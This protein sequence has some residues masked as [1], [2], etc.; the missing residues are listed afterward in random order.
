[1]AGDEQEQ[2]VDGSSPHADRV[3][4][5][6]AHLQELLRRQ[7]LG[8]APEPA[9]A[10][11][12]PRVPRDGPLPLS[13]AQQRLWYL[14]EIES[15]SIEYNT[16]RV[17]RL[18][19]DLDVEALASALHGLVL[20]HEPLR[21]S[22][23]SVDGV[24]VQV[25]HPGADVPVR[26]ADLSELP[27][28]DRRAALDRCVLE[29]ATCPFDLRN[30]PV[31]RVRLLRLGPRDHVLAVSMH[32]IVTDGWSLGVLVDDLAVLY[33]AGLG[34]GHDDLPPLLAHFADLAAWQRGR[35]SSPAL[36]DRL[37]YWCRALDGLEP[38][39]LPTDL[40]RPPVRTAVG[41]LH[42]FQIPAPVTAQLR[43]L[44]RDAGATLFMTLVT[45][46]QV[47]LARWSG[48]ADVAV[49]TAV[50][51]RDRVEAERLIGFFVNTLVLRTRVDES[52]SA[53]DL[54]RVVRSTVL[55]A[56]A[57]AEVPFQQVVEALRPDRDPS[58]PALAEVAVNLRTVPG[59]AVPW[60]GLRVAE[61][62]PPVV[63]ASMDLSFDFVD[64]DGVLEAH[65]GYSTDLFT[66]A[67][68]R[69]M[70]VHLVT[71]LRG[72]AERPGGCVA[73]LPMLGRGERRRLTGL[74]PGSGATPGTR[75]A[76]QLFAAQVAGNPS[77][78]AVISDDVQLSYAEL[79]ERANRMAR[80]LLSRGAG[81]EE[82]VAVALPPSIDMIVAVLAV[83]KSG[84]A[85]LPLDPDH[86]AERLRL[87][88]AD[89]RPLLLVTTAALEQRFPAS[90]PKIVVDAPEVRASARRLPGSELAGHE[91]TAPLLAAHPAY[92]TYTSG[93]TGHPKGVVV[94]HAGV[95]D[96][97]TGQ[98]EQFRAGR[99]ARVLQF[100]SLCFDAAFSEL[101]MSLLSGGTLVVAT[102]EQMLPGDPLAALMARHR[103][104]HVTLPPSALT[105]LPEAGIAGDVTLIV[106][107]EACPPALARKWSARRRMINAYGP[108]EA[109]VCASMSAPLVPAS[110]PAATVPIGRPFGGVRVHVLDGW[111]R[112]VPAGVPG[113]I[114][115]SG[116]ALARGYLHRR[117]LTAQRFV[118]AP[119]G[120]PGG[121]MYRTGDRARW[122]GDGTLDFL[123][124]VDD[125]VKLRGFRIELGE[126][127]AVLSRHHGVSGVAAAVRQDERGTRRLV[128]YVTSSA[129]ALD[130]AQLRAF[131]RQRLPEH[132]VPSVI[133]PLDQLPLNA[134][135]K[136]D[137]RALPDPGPRRDPTRERVA[138]RNPAEETLVRI[139]AE[140]L[141]V[142][143]IGV[144]DNFFDLG[145]DS[146][147]SLQVVARAREAGLQLTAKQTF[148][149]PTIA[150][151]AV[152]AI[153]ASGD[154]QP[155]PAEQHARSG[156]V[157]LTP[158]QH[159]FFDHL[160][161]SL[162]QFSQSIFL[163][164]T[165]DLHEGA[166]VAAITALLEQHDALRMRATRSS[167]GWRLTIAPAEHGEVVQ[168]ADLSDRD[169][170]EQDAVM[171]AATA[172]A[173]VGFPL[174]TGPM[175][176]ARLFLL[177][178]QRRPRLF[179]AA[180]HL[181][182]DG[183]SWPILL[184]DL[185]TGYRQA[186]RGERI[187]LRPRTSSFRGWAIRLTEFVAAGGLAGDAD[188]WAGAEAAAPA[189]ARLPLD[190]Q[191][192]NTV[193][194]MRT[195]TATLDAASTAALFREVP[196][197]Y[198]TR[199]DDV[200]LS[201]LGRVLSAWTGHGPVLIAVEG[202][203]RE[204]LFD[205]ADLSRTVGWFT[206]LFPLALTIPPD[207]DWGE[208]LKS[209]KEQVRAVPRNGLS[210]GALRYLGDRDA[211]LGHGPEPEVSFNYLGQLFAAEAESRLAHR[212]L[213]D[214]G[215]ERS[216]R[217]ERQ[218]L[219][220][221]NS[222]VRDGELEFRWS[223][224][225]TLHHQET[226]E[227]LAWALTTAVKEII[228]HCARPG[229]GGRTPSD[230]PLAS[231]DRAAVD[232]IA[233]DGRSVAD[234]YPLTP[235][236]SGILFHALSEA[237]RDIYTGHFGAR[238]DGITDPEALA[239]AWQR[240]VDRTPAL[241]TA[242]IWQDVA[243]P[244]QVVYSEARVP[245]THYD[246][247]AM[248][249]DEQQDALDLVWEERAGFRFDLTAA[250]LL[251]L[252]IVR[253]TDTA[254]QLFWTTHHMV[255]DGWSFADVLA[256]VFQQYAILTGR[257]Q[258][259]P[260]ARRPF[261]DY[262]AWL[263]G[264]D[265]AEAERYWRAVMD[266]FTVPTPLP[267][268]RP[269]VRA[270]ETRSSRELRLSM[271][272]ER[273]RR[274]YEYAR[275]AR[276]TVN[277]VVQGAWAILLSRYTG[278][279][280][281]C[282]GATVSG[283]PPALAGAESV[284][285]LFINTVPV[286]IDVDGQSGVTDWLRGI[287]E[288][289]LDS[290]SH[291]Y[292][293]LSQ[294]QQVSGVGG[295]P[296]GS[297]LFNSILVF[298]NYPHHSAA[299]ARYGLRVGD[300]LGDEHTNYA[301]TCT[302]YAA[303]EL[304]LAVGYDP[305][306]FDSSTIE[307]MAG[308]LVT[309]LGAVATAPDTAVA[310]LPMLT[311]AETRQLLVERN[312]TAV[313][314][315]P[316]RCV[317]E[318][319]AEQVRSTPEAMAVSSAG[320][321]L[322]FAG[323]EERANQLAHYLTGQGAGP[324]VL[325]GVCLGRGS[326][327]VIALLAVLK[328]GSAFVPLDPEYPAQRLKIMLADAAVPVVITEQPLLD[329]VAGHD[330]AIVCL[331]RDRPLL[332]GLPSEPPQTGVTPEDLAYVVYTSGTTG[333]PKGVMVEHRQVHHMVRA[334]DAR[335]GLA[336]L[337]PR[338]MSVSSLSVDLF[339]GDFLLATLF[340]GSLVVCPQES[341]ADPVALVDLLVQTR[342]ALM[343]TVPTLA[344]AVAAEFAWRGERP[345]SLRL[346]MV[347]S[348]G[349]PADAAAEV[350]AALGPRTVVVN[351]YG[352]TETTV[353]SSVFA[354]EAE[355]VGEAA[356]VPI[357]RPLANTRIYLLDAQLRPV[358]TG[359]AGEC[360]I[361]GDGISRG[362]W[363]GPAI[364]AER[365]LPDPFAAQPG[366]RMYRTGDLVRWRAD[367]NLEYLGRADDQVKVGG[368]RVELG[369]VEAALARHPQVA[370]ASAAISQK[371][372]GRPARLVGY[373]VPVTGAEPDPAEL[374]LF[375]A[376]RLP[377][378]AVPSVLM[379]L[380][381]LPFNPGGTI[382]RRA[383]PA[384]AD[385]VS[386]RT[387]YLAPRSG[388]ERVLAQIWAEVLD[389]ERV[390]VH[391]NFFD[392]GGNSILSIRV[393]S[394]IRTELHLAASPRQLF[395]TPT[396]AGTAAT[397]DANAVADAG[398]EPAAWSATDR[399]G[400]PPLSLAQQRL[401]FLNEFEPE[402]AEYN[403][404]TVLR[405]HGEL[406]VDA[407]RAAL[408]QVVARHEPLRTTYADVAGRAAQVIHRAPM[409]VLSLLDL[410]A[411]AAGE[412]EVSMLR[413]ARAEAARPFDL[414][415]GPVFR[416]TLI[417]LGP[418][419]HVMVLVVH[420]IAAD[421]WSMG[422]LTDELGA[423]YSAAR[424]GARA[425]LPPLPVRYADY[426]GWQR[427]LLSE[428]AMKEHAKYWLGKLEGLRPLELPTDR[429]RPAVRTAEGQL[430]LVEIDSSVAAALKDLARQ[431]D[432]TLFMAL[433]AAVQVLLAR[434]SGQHDIAVGV[435]T[436]GR[437]RRE[438]E[439]LIGLF[440]NTVV[441]RCTVE[442]E[443]SFPEFLARVRATMLEAFVHAEMPFDGLVEIMRPR[444]DPSR[445]AL[446][447][448]FVGLEE[449][450]SSGPAMPGL[451]VEAVP[452][453]SGQ[454]SHDVSFDF[455]ER[456]GRLTA[457]IGYGTALF[458]DESIERLAGHLQALLAGIAGR[459]RRLAGLPMLS[460][461][462]HRRLTVEWN[463][464]RRDVPPV[465][466]VGLFESQVAAT[467]D[468]TALVC[469][470][471]V[472]T[473]AEVNER[474]NRLAH[475]LVS[476]GIGPEHLVALAGA[477]SVATVV[478]ILAV[479][480]AGVGYLPLDPRE[481]ADR[482]AFALH[483]AAPA[484]VLGDDLPENLA[485]YPATNLADADRC[486][487]L[488]PEH[489]AYVI[490][491]SG[492]TGAPKGVVIEHRNLAN[493]FF[494][495]QDLLKPAAG[496][497][498]RTGLVAPFTFD[499]ALVGLTLLIGGHELHILDDLTR[500]DPEA[501]AEYVVEH[502]I[503]HLDLTPSFAAQLIAAGL[504]SAPAHRPALLTLAGEAIGVP[505]WE[506]LRAAVGTVSYNCYGPTECTVD[507][508]YQRIGDT[509]RPVI[510]GPLRNARAYV[511]DGYLRPV[512]AG[513]PGELY[514]AGAQLGRG[515]LNRPELTAER[516]VAGPFGG[517]G[518]RMYRTGDMARWTA[519][520][521]IEYLGR[522]DDQVKVRG[523][524]IE[525]G[526]I[527]EVLSRCP[528]VGRA[529]TTVRQ[530]PAGEPMIVA[531]L[532]SPTAV[533]A[534][535][536]RDFA[537][538]TLP[539]YMVP[540]A[541]V[542]VR[543]FPLTASGK[544]DRMA[545]PA[546]EVIAGPERQYVAPR[547]A[548][549]E[550]LAGIWADVLG[551]DRVGAEDNFFDLG[552]E[553]ILSIQVVH[554]IRRAGLR[555]TAKDLFLNQTI[556]E[557][558]PVIGR[559][560]A[561]TPDDQQAVAGPVPLTPIQREFLDGD[562]V[563]PHHFTQSTLVELVDDLNEDALRSA[564]AALPVQHDSLRMRYQRHNGSWRQYAPP[565]TPVPADPLRRC[566][567][568]RVPEPDRRAAMHRLAAETDASLDLGNGPLW[569][570]LLFDFGAGQRPWLF[571]TVHHLVTDAVSWRILLDDLELAYRQ[572]AQGRP[573]RLGDK[574]TSFQRWSE[575]LA[576]HVADAALDEELRHWGSLPPAVPVPVDGDGP[577]TVDSIATV[578]LS[579]D[580]RE[581]DLLLHR[582]VGV[583]RSRTNDIL[584]GGL[585]RS[586]SRWTGQP[587]VLI[588][589]EGHGREDIFDDLDLSRTVGWFTTLYPVAIEIPDADGDWPALLKSV[590]RQLRAVPGNG[591]GYSALRYLSAPGALG[592]VLAG[593]AR[594]QVLF[595]YHGR[596]DSASAGADSVLYH[597]FHPPI[598]QE[599]N[600]AERLSHL[601]EVVG[602]VQDRKLSFTWYYSRNAHH[603][604]TMERVAEDFRDTLRFIARYV[605]EQ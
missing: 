84:A 208:V 101:G 519:D 129:E 306:L 323:L 371:D 69:R 552:G 49:S 57:H 85:Y 222:L 108:T 439:G 569:R 197:V 381:A 169:P 124:R 541:F 483:D 264:Q 116:P 589:V 130:G 279:R 171:R 508:L 359:V 480:K 464:T 512:P 324:G 602:A 531:Y 243:E 150:E 287:Q 466:V 267:S 566:D 126:V 14:H 537:R 386:T 167:G 304:Q 581:S 72:I 376:E 516:F 451:R 248:S 474:V 429:P 435:P 54:L 147:L 115:L 236:Q 579:L 121:R 285:G 99:G 100:A 583:F 445:N 441:L 597:A 450:R 421:G 75:T 190:G 544:V 360:Y 284:I 585:A 286:R 563:A 314:N 183:V 556:A 112:P 412:R 40:P 484:L 159:W 38:L 276:L 4:A 269:L 406:D 463:D 487:P 436:S 19:G 294:I 290:R 136:I 327:V 530:G 331:D 265:R 221:I 28:G 485:G 179:L 601:I 422:V 456:Q 591:L 453:V 399:A 29:E 443:L 227:R 434:Y 532:T 22:F 205:G 278:E 455:V 599:Q 459:H 343:V 407:L 333:R 460:E 499:A 113:E 594:P 260:A 204:E 148:L 189:A 238:L 303:D 282:F 605:A 110:I 446:A 598:G 73:D 300:Y 568:T 283:R 107:G 187:D 182:V 30:G 48:R 261:R 53:T 326:D 413:H 465:T 12:I 80:L 565:A 299:A 106:A 540:A 545:L 141:G 180:H 297:S 593:R 83:L 332:D 145:G 573:I 42:R 10:S 479:L 295:V 337:K 231:L 582:A 66:P 554:R 274:L 140:L 60:P 379:V 440:V 493:L 335:Y 239:L 257:H 352:S 154:G 452:F 186:C 207:P 146:I 137:R 233:A 339:F 346:L 127:E 392:L 192:A 74:W 24:G 153:A 288:S 444:R 574:T 400:P 270:H 235:T 542:F 39:D 7:L 562:P 17:L 577:G 27:A 32:H 2:A 5:L 128:A 517:P 308:H 428:P 344:R 43:D 415:E 587:R 364:T 325:V 202:H 301:L 461:A 44:S 447:E 523:F 255:V 547:N 340:G 263:A 539:G 244:V 575:R 506:E 31:F 102:R 212:R 13:P 56:L 103:I 570:A 81:P 423:C 125:Q 394:R 46:V 160:H 588:D 341:V 528:G 65:L 380:E 225:A 408:R 418:A 272:P 349:W 3:A 370:V 151:L 166:L 252:S 262:V 334:W 365:F 242:V 586:L 210:Y 525:L 395:D 6:P 348:E 229:A 511:L 61:L 33:A 214:E 94:T 363:N 185:D 218:Q 553:S 63:T 432:A 95:E 280:D 196:E 424:H 268:D 557:L 414:R 357:G 578:S 378:P 600:P 289:Q 584:F 315:P 90:V 342:A 322:T 237:G 458:D 478:S 419:E 253:L 473:F 35:L 234:I 26:F 438:L 93:S 194:S 45:A 157:P 241:R 104:T 442:E 350:L 117:D 96:L 249:D 510:G 217:Q 70:A 58:R 1:M 559:A 467:P 16:I 355:L 25:V 21:T 47:L 533:T 411:A 79:N 468:R 164:L 20:R 275:N 305:A 152:Q 215:V 158:I 427:A 62:Q 536:L 133:V 526:E 226:I 68:V 374:R 181:V 174:E 409:T 175:V 291:E 481:P 382:N 163:E 281:V 396:V 223:Y 191:G 91:L 366:I 454:V 330:A 36:A 317:Q 426:A 372:A 397:I 37:G 250:P 168:R 520:G 515:Y 86:P 373:V 437:D 596:A 134:N 120:A 316:A 203:G 89:A 220:E 156:D 296:A 524:R 50:S 338:C 320:E 256:D 389:A 293:S 172:S 494:G 245:V 201:A 178:R 114:Y 216:P 319:F 232:R 8:Q 211:A 336:K 142:E 498:L 518:R 92:V 560:E 77:A 375:A 405:L 369:E 98:A 404:V 246:C 9:A 251:R 546:P 431:Q 529:A 351:A 188:Y 449:E 567:L 472:L 393:I 184:S 420:H 198:R 144:E 497:P 358:P 254:V 543:E 522:T 23:E 52:C 230:F 475:Y 302:A 514:L 118:A 347:G 345:A 476:C 165:A 561:R 131:A 491:T 385:A 78:A 258:G 482:R 534:A 271:S 313:T 433:V 119:L 105:A 82:I 15:D 41:A 247:R 132:M 548:V 595:A 11:I 503:D 387:T 383:L 67:T 199:I 310:R 576:Q 410:S 580:E 564:L 550:I 384:P 471:E 311:D 354:L 377:A 76:P 571:I 200:L 448:V 34:G 138:P 535:E 321:E 457:A 59:S 505:L 402:S 558:A 509:A 240:V 462:E 87:I 391:D 507:S 213:P 111:L 521:T 549:E 367:G 388:T 173:Q 477:R 496:R 401:W 353:D 273:S 502:R 328:A 504:L 361:G 162:D 195:V 176:R 161:D 266:G 277:T 603:R 416:A 551:L 155:P 312:D 403:I 139:W 329:R 572:A 143:R 71:L 318:L 430:R 177:G 489:P 193:A 555:V 170:G 604:A 219:I 356:F 590:R 490:Y 149:Q 307:R 18:S 425:E 51:G 390:G 513:V 206:S 486:A 368:F 470:S 123:G 527:D 259:S 538:R 362:Y 55:D 88:T 228:E 64:N 398:P 97:V 495:Y 109:T 592:A 500:R 122:L 292:L 501:L 309:L 224:S 492:S 135:G 417:Q 209:V 298:E 469:G 488:R